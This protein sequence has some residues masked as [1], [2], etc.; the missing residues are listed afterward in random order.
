MPN[1]LIYECP[2]AAEAIIIRKGNH[3]ELQ[4][5]FRADVQNIRTKP[6][7]KTLPTYQ[8]TA[9]HLSCYRIIRQ[10]ESLSRL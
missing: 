3:F 10:S 6:Y 8:N 4:T 5:F 7:S 9:S 2:V 1:N